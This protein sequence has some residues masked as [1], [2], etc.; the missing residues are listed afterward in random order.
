MHCLLIP[1]SKS[2]PAAL[3]RLAGLFLNG[4]LFNDLG[5]I[6]RGFAPFE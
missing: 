2:N 5:R 6:L 1:H 4:V 3:L